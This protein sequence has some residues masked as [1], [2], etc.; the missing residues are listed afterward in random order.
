MQKFR[1]S[2][3]LFAFVI[4]LQACEVFDSGK[5]LIWTDCPEVASYAELFNSKQ[6]SVSVR[7]IYQKSLYKAFTTQEEKPDLVIGRYLKSDSILQYLNPVDSFFQKLLVSRG[8][9][10]PVLLNAGTKD[11]RQYLIPVSYNLPLAIFLKKNTQ[12]I[13]SPSVISVSEIAK[14]AKAFNNKTNGDFSQMGFGFSWY[15]EFLLNLSVLEGVDFKQ[16]NPLSWNEDSFEK[17]SKKILEL[18]ESTNENAQA[19]DTFQFKY[20]YNPDYISLSAGRILY[21][22]RNTQSYFLLPDDIRA[23]LDF[24]YISDGE[25]I[26]VDSNIVFLGS[27]K[28]I[29]SPKASEAFVQWFFS[30]EGQREILEREKGYRGLE[31]NFGFC[32]GFSAVKTITE[33][34]FPAYYP[35][36]LGHIILS[37]S[38]VAQKALPYTYPDLLKDGILPFLQQLAF[39]KVDA[40]KSYSQTLKLK[41]DM[42]RN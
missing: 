26:P 29:K 33:K 41:L 4:L 1:L 3:F 40:G 31:T 20:L 8:S 28:N 10:Y 13:S 16:G 30:E 42:V 38:L 12:G 21:S 15:P 17:F 19:E 22:Y 11:A 9:F 18:T 36:L 14:E 32:G 7:V 24:R 5:S 27:G 35:A 34:I 37:D 2:V 25:N 23:N 39:I 6:N